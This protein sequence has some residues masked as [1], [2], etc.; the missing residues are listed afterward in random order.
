[1]DLIEAR[2]LLENKQKIGNE[3]SIW[4]TWPDWKKCSELLPGSKSR[5]DWNFMND[6]FE[7][8]MMYDMEDLPS[9]LD[10]S[11]FFNEYN[12]PL[13]D[14]FRKSEIDVNFIDYICDDPRRALTPLG[15]YT[16]LVLY[17][18]GYFE[19]SPKKIKLFDLSKA[20]HDYVSFFDIGLKAKL[21]ENAEWDKRRKMLKNPEIVLE[22]EFNYSILNDIF[23][24]KVGAFV[25][26]K[27]LMIG[28]ILVTKF[29]D[30]PCRSNS[31]K[32]K[33]HAVEFSWL[34]QSGKSKTITKRSRY[35][36]NRRNTI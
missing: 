6:F 21:K 23:F 31:G 13:L 27:E 17:I 28:N 10:R 18:N 2:A 24:E 19:A 26:E 36:S 29:V 22:T 25:G 16:A 11:E 1:M 9:Y 15:F 30:T 34:S 32:S 35:E 12:K 5:K 33:D 8:W 7:N 14:T 20:V 4:D 3:N